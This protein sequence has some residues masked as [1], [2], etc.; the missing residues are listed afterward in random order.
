MS[1]TATDPFTAPAKGGDK[2]PLDELTGAL[3]LFTV[4]SVE[5]GIQTTF[6]ESDAVKCDVAA[7][8]GSHKAD[9]FADTLIFPRVLRSQLAGQVGGMVLGRLG[10]GTAKPGQSA[11]WILADPTDDDKDTARKYIAY[12]AS[13]TAPASPF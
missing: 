8:D 9:V 11:P 10:K 1:D 5:T 6:G 7:L 4:K 13:Q 3:L 12:V 2:L